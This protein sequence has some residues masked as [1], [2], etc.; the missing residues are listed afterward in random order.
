MGR[1]GDGVL[2]GGGWEMGMDY[3]FWYAVFSF[4]TL[5]LLLCAEIV[6]LRC[7]SCVS[8]QFDKL[9]F[10]KFERCVPQL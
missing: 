9:L 3:V 8:G 1:G 5:W 6:D 7:R 4:F 10:G 2:V